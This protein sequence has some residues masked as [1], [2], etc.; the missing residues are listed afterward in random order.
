MPARILTALKEEDDN[1]R[2]N[3]DSA[4]EASIEKKSEDVEEAKEEDTGK[5]LGE[6]EE[7][8]EVLVKQELDD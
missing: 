5:Q 7:I 4:A 3:E 2:L 1:E 8:S 6:I